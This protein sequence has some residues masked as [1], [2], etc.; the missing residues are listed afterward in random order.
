MLEPKDKKHDP[1]ILL[2]FKVY[3]PDED[4]KA[5]DTVHNALKQ[6]EEKQCAA[7][8][9]ASGVLADH[10]RTYGVAFQG[11][12]VQIGKGHPSSEN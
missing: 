8:L 2:E 11:K 12:R 6:I 9:I 3:D 4:K 10:I 5:E 1:G 7:S